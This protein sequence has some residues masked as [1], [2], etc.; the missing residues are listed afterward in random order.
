MFVHIFQIKMRLSRRRKI[1]WS[2]N[3]RD[4]TTSNMQYKV[5]ESDVANSLDFNVFVTCILPI[6]HL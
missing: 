1:R 2:T 6:A 5:S 3:Q 4:S